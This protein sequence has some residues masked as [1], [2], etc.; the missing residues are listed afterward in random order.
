MELEDDPDDAIKQRI[1]SYYEIEKKQNE[2]EKMFTG[3]VQ[4]NNQQESKIQQDT[5]IQEKVNKRK[6]KKDF[7]NVKDDKSNE[8]NEYC[9]KNNTKESNKNHLLNKKRNREDI[10]KE[11]E[12]KINKRKKNY[13]N[14]SKTTKYGQPIMKYRIQNILTNIKTKISKGII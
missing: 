4:S 5:L 6:T 9:K 8:N 12:E 3:G 1:N 2:F 13:R 10:E 14:L 11:K 7:I